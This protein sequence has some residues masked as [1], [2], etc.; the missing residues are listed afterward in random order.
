MRKRYDTRAQ[1]REKVDDF[2]EAVLGHNEFPRLLRGS[3]GWESGLEDKEYYGR[4]WVPPAAI[5]YFAMT[6]THYYDTDPWKHSPVREAPVFTPKP[7][8][9]IETQTDW[10]SPDVAPSN[11]HQTDGS[12]GHLGL[13]RRFQ[14]FARARGDEIRRVEQDGESLPD[15]ELSPDEGV[16]NCAGI[17][18]DSDIVNVEPEWKNETKPANILTN[19]ERAV[20][21]GRHAILVFDSKSSAEK[22]YKNLRL[23]INGFTEHGAQCYQGGQIPKVDDKMLVINQDESDWYLTHDG[24]AER[25]VDGEVR[26]RCS[27]EADLTTVEHDCATARKD[28]DRYIVTT[29]DG[30]TLTYG[31]RA[32]FQREWTRVTAP[33]I[34]I[35]LCY[36]PYVTIMYEKGAPGE[37]TGDFAKFEATPEW[38]RADGAG[39]RSTEFGAVIAQDFLN[40]V[41]GSEIRVHEVRDTMLGLYNWCTEKKEP[42]LEWFGRGF[43]DI[44]RTDDD[45]RK[46]LV[47]H[48]WIFPRGLVSPHLSS[49]DADADLDLQ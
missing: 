3:T 15:Q 34:P 48:T 40:E 37:E 8:K 29:R 32:A 5:G 2:I 13:G 4:F 45:K 24:M 14:D 25:V 10:A 7:L 6:Y 1:H 22:A 23:P 27:A 43:P 12:D 11:R 9:E 18:V 30:E 47:D 31:S 16:V 33:H 26:T 21:D 49:V 36:L 20:A 46:A 35:D 28:G 41:P 44:D 17:H 19:V 39:Q 42:S 38:E